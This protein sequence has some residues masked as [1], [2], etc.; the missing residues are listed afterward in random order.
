MTERPLAADTPLEFERMQFAALRAMSPAQRFALFDSFQQEMEELAEAGIRFR[1]PLADSKEVF[2]RRVATRLDPET[3]ETMTM[4][5]GRDPGQGAMNDIKVSRVVADLTAALDAANIEFFVA[6]SI[7][8]IMHGEFRT[9][10]DVDL[11]VDL[12]ADDV[13]RVVAAMR[14]AFH[15]DE[16]SVRDAMR[17]CAS[18]Q[19][20]HLATWMRVDLFLLRQRPY[21]EVEMKRRVRLPL[22]GGTCVPVASPEDSVLAKLEWYRKGDE[23]SD[24]QWRD[25]QG[26]LKLQRERLDLAYLRRWAPELGVADLLERAFAD[27]GIAG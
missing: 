21:S 4:R 15:L 17:H 19:A 5:Y 20:V 12:D 22:A 10:H 25:V 7:S 14:G 6:G 24:R 16:E 8:S 23:V 9:T 2:L 1:H 26:I 11:V 13:P 18:F 3:M 27:A